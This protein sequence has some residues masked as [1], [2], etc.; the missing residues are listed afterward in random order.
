MCRNDTILGSVVVSMKTN[1]AFKMF[2][3]VFQKG[4]HG[5]RFPKIACDTHTLFI[6]KL[7]FAIPRKAKLISSVF[8]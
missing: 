5:K 8:N 2:L 7:L 4:M 1:R 3:E 6:I